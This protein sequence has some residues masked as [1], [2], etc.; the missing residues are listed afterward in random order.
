MWPKYEV[1]HH[2][3]YASASDILIST[4]FNMFEEI[5]KLV[6]YDKLYNMILL[7]ERVVAHWIPYYREQRG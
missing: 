6:N 4:Y 7:H 2:G 5:S 1:G 3:R